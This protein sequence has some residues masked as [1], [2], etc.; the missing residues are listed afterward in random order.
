[1]SHHTIT[2]AKN[3]NLFSPLCWYRKTLLMNYG[4]KL[5]GRRDFVS[6]QALPIGDPYELYDDQD[7]TGKADFVRAPG[8]DKWIWWSDLPEKTQKVLAK[9]VARKDY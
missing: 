1:M 8:S 3:R 4:G 5:I 9:R 7:C 6:I 2:H